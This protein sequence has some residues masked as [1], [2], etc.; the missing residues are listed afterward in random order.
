MAQSDRLARS[1]LQTR[2]LAVRAETSLLLFGNMSLTR[3]S[4]RVCQEFQ[5]GISRNALAGIIHVDI[6]A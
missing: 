6:Q 4:R 2:P 1:F 5:A 3:S